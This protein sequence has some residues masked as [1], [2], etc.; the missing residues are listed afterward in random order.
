MG[1]SVLLRISQIARFIFEFPNDLLGRWD[2]MDG[3]AD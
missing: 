1:Y 2:K 3:Q